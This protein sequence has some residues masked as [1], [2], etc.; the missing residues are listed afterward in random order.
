MNRKELLEQKDRLQKELDKLEEMLKALPK[1]RWRAENGETYYFLAA[2]STIMDKTE[3][4]SIA[5]CN[6]FNRGNYFR[7]QE[8]A[9]DYDE[10]LRTKYALIDLAH[11]LNDGK[12]IDWAC[13][14]QRKYFL[15]VNMRNRTQCLE[16]DFNVHGKSAG[17][18]YCL[19]ENFLVEAEKL[20]G[21]QAIIDMIMAGV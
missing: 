9:Y 7:T 16:T 15:R 8:E 12:E 3:L 18:V 20:L 4:G 17:T 6:R 11:E 2:D 14:G 5:D 21:E 19:R 1:G 10:A 13:L